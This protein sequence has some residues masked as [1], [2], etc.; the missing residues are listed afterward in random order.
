MKG[1]DE[2]GDDDEGGD[3]EEREDDPCGVAHVP[4]RYVEGA[5]RTR[6]AQ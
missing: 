5:G 3:D 2:A 1:E 4:L 6:R